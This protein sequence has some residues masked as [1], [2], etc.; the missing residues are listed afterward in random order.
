MNGTYLITFVCYGA[1]IPGQEGIIH[2]AQNRFGAPCLAADPR[3]F[4]RAKLLMTEEPYRMDVQRRAVVLQSV[5]DLCAR[6]GWLLLAAHIRPTHLHVIVEAGRTPELVMTALKASASASL[7]RLGIDGCSSRR[8]ARHG[9]TR[10][11]W[12]P[13]DLSAA[14]HYLQSG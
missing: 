11:L 4:A 9:S 2:R 6:R 13:E 3:L 8:W 12:N 1:R 5:R 14:I 7:N 10:Y